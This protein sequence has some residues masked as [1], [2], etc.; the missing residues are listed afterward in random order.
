MFGSQEA[1]KAAATLTQ[2]AEDFNGAMQ[3]MSSSAGVLEQAFAKVDSTT[4]RTIAKSLNE[5]KNTSIELGGAI[6]NAAAP[7]IEQFGQ[8]VGKLSAWLQSL[9]PAPAPGSR[10]PWPLPDSG[11]RRA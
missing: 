1:A 8:M 11:E 10:T 5:L 3:S 7:A 2:H 4:Q 9:T 6:L